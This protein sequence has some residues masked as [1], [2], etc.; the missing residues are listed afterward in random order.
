MLRSVMSARSSAPVSCDV[1]EKKTSH[2]AGGRNEPA[3][4][5]YKTRGLE[6]GRLVCCAVS[7]SST[8]QDTK[9]QRDT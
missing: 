7:S 9:T 2:M 8:S 3:S 6:V 4:V 5:G 1:F